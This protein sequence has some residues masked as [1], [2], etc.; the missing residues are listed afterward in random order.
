MI[1]LGLWGNTLT[2]PGFG[3]PAF[4]TAS[5]LAHEI[6]HNLGRGH[7]GEVVGA[8]ESNCNPNYQSVMSYLFQIQGLSNS[9]DRVID[10]SRQVLPLINESS[11]PVGLGTLTYWPSWFAPLS[12]VDQSL[13]T[14]VAQRHCDGSRL[15]ATDVPMV[16]IEGTDTLTLPSAGGNAI[17]WNGDLQANYA[18]GLD[19]GP[20]DVTFNGVINGAA[21]PLRGSD[22]WSFISSTG[23]AQLGTRR[24]AGGYSVDGKD[25][26]GKDFSGKDFSGKDF[27]GKDFSGK[28]FSGKDFSGKDFSGKDFSGDQEFE[29]AVA[30]ANPATSMKARQESNGKTNVAVRL[31]WK[32]P[33][34]SG[35]RGIQDYVVYRVDG[36]R[37][38]FDNVSR[39]TLVATRS[40]PPPPDPTADKLFDTKVTAGKSYTYFAVVRYADGTQ[41]G[42]SNQSS[43]TVSK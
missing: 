2:P 11:L 39:R 9:G 3:A 6:G 28:D 35:S 38:T 21:Q 31:T 34:L 4:V 13:G 33:T 29:R 40:T 24:T 7:S 30:V 22:D 12:S 19:Q 14:S 17:D 16:Q 32:A 5:T 23:L 37:L 8:F 10:F 43:L 26:S 36:L 27:S 41:S 18:A 42:K 20:A 1:S 25:F 15:L